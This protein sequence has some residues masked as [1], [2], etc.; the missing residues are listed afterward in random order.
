[1]KKQKFTNKFKVGDKVACST[2]GHKLQL[3]YN[4]VYGF[5]YGNVKEILS[6]DTLKILWE[7]QNYNQPLYDRYTGKLDNYEPIIMLANDIILADEKLSELE[8]EYKDIEVEIIN[9]IQSAYQLILDANDLSFKI[10]LDTH[11]LTRSLDEIINPSY[12]W[13]GSSLSC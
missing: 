12:G 1:M 6:K 4:P 9:K 7:E 11:Q 3:T 5:I 10:N 2:N 13:S 8:K